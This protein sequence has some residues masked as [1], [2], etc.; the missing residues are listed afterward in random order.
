MIGRAGTLYTI[1]ATTNGLDWEFVAQGI[2]ESE[3]FEYLDRNASSLGRQS[4]RVSEGSHAPPATAP[5]I[6]EFNRL[7]DGSPRLVIEAV[8]G[9]ALSLQFSRNLDEWQDLQTFIHPGGKIELLDPDAE[10]QGTKFYR[11]A[12][13]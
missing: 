2:V 10:D 13:P 3:Q 7:P 9:R 8:G 11:L 6:V 12:M 5:R 1:E 4:Y